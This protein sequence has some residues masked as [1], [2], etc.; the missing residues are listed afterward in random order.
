MAPYFTGI[1]GS[2]PDRG[3]VT[4]REVFNLEDQ[5]ANESNRS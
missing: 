2:A 1:D 3:F 4:L 5:L